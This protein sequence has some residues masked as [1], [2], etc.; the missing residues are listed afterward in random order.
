MEQY[1]APARDGAA[2]R[3]T[4]PTG[5]SYVIGKFG[6][7]LVPAIFLVILTT[8]LS[9]VSPNFLSVGNFLDIA[10]VVSIIGIM[11]VGMTIVILT[12][13]ID[14][15]VGSTFAF[16]AVVTASL[17]PGSFSDAP[18][19]VGADLPVPVAI[20]VGLAIGAGIGFVNGAII[21]KSRVEPF[22]VTLATMAFV[23]GLTYLF[24]G[25]FPTIFRPMP[26]EFE[27]VGQGYVMGL[28]TPVVFFALVIVM[29]V[30]L[31]RRTT[32]GRS[33]YAIGGNEEASRL[34]GIKVHWIKIQAYTLMGML[35]A[36]SGIILSSR[37]GAAQPTA[38]LTYELD[39]IAGVVIGGTS[40]MGGRG[41]ILSTVLG[42]FI[43]GVIS[44]GLNIVG[45]PTYYQYVV[46]GL[47]LIFAVG[48]DAHLRKQ[49][50]H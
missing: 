16:A 18:T 45:V 21:A 25:G 10:R 32:F 49:Q 46:K 11:A 31:T 35:A 34:S 44:N 20:L 8:G 24:T 38:G 41:S 30:W 14:L 40:L 26:A 47:L 19:L 5:L 29:G 3:L 22:I 36:L 28:P 13:G 9:L 7:Q 6:D 39:V 48:L 50:R 4:A 17:I 37:V 42:V 27:W 1:G 23:R 12:G 33:V 2:G 43:L 15:S